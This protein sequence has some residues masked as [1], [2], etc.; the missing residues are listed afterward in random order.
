MDVEGALAAY[1]ALRVARRVQPTSALSP[2]TE[3]LPPELIFA[4]FGNLDASG[5]VRL[6]STSTRFRSEIVKNI[7]LLCCDILDTRDI[8]HLDQI[9]SEWVAV[10]VLRAIVASRCEHRFRNRLF[11]ARYYRDL[12][13]RAATASMVGKVR[14]VDDETGQE[15][16]GSRRSP[17]GYFTFDFSS[18][19]LVVFTK[20]S[21]ELRF[22]V[23]TLAVRRFVCWGTKKEI[24]N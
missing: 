9:L 24:V 13:R 16:G 1:D 15:L 23:G 8:A 3:R 12:E 11:L 5:L 20:S 19:S 6:S 4:I 18:S 21:V 7:G 10:R 2:M 17:S 14:V 22:R